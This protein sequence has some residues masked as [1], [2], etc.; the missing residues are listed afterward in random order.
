[1]LEPPTDPID[2]AYTHALIEAYR[3]VIWERDDVATD[4]DTAPVPPAELV[5]L[6]RLRARAARVDMN[7]AGRWS[8]S[9]LGVGGTAYLCTV[10]GAGMGVSLI[11]SNFSGIGSG[12]SAGNTGVWLHNRGGGFTLTPGHPNELAPGRRPLHTLSP[13][14]WTKGD[15]LDMVVG[16]RGG[17]QQPQLLA[18][19]AA[20]R[21]HVGCDLAE[22]IAHPR[23]TIDQLTSDESHITVENRMDAAVLDGLSERGHNASMGESW[24]G[25]WGPISAIELDDTGLRDAVADPRVDTALALAT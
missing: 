22:A 15:R 19:I 7:H 18:Q 17:H 2:P 5:S 25:G 14:M 11:Q 8:T 1:M 20:H 6:E 3:A 12:L 13:T 24:V 21:F 23:W 4:P 16:T 9:G 10:D